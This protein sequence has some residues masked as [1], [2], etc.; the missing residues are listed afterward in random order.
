MIKVG[1]LLD[2][3]N[4]WIKK[5]LAG[6]SEDCELHIKYKFGF[7]CSTEKIQGYEIVFILGFT[8]ILPRSFLQS[9]KLNLV[10]HESDLPAGKGFSPVQRQI[11]EGRNRIPVCLIEAVEELDSGD[12]LG[13]VHMELE[14]YELFDEIRQKQAAA[15]V[16]LIKN[17]LMQY[18]QYTR[19]EQ[20]GKSSFYGKRNKKDDELDVNKTILEQFDH[21]RVADNQRYPLYF[22]VDGHKYYLRITTR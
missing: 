6:I 15:T 18:P 14:G 1:I 11:L 16:E 4:N 8:K 21:F 2:S 17:F 20:S 19:I 9:N 3:E 22:V 7:S 10:V 13:K 12:I 5:Y